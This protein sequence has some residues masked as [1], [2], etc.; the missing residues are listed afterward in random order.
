MAEIFEALMVICFGISWPV[1]IV[2]SWKSE[3]AKGKSLVFL[4]FIL[5]GYLCGMISKIIAG[6]ITYVFVFY[7]LNFIMVS[8]DL[9]L[10]FRNTKLDRQREKTPNI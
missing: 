1:S 4:C 5:I 3:T 7:V 10:Y 6:K 8:V 9:C 2:K